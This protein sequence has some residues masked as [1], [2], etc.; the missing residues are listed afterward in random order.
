MP[1]LPH[2]LSAIVNQEEE[3]EEEEEMS[4]AEWGQETQALMPDLA[5]SNPM[6][7]FQTH[8]TGAL[9]WMSSQTISSSPHDV[10][11]VPSGS[12]LHHL[13]PRPCH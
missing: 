1:L 12:L 8:E 11:P 5:F 2:V 13:V 6:V 4:I 9:V 7:N 10:S 3:E